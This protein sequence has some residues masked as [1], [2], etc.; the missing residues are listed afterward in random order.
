MLQKPHISNQYTMPLHSPR[1]HGLYTS[2]TSARCWHSR[3]A[4]FYP[5]SQKPH[6]CHLATMLP[7]LHRTHGPYTCVTSHLYRHSRPAPSDQE[8]QKKRSDFHLATTPM[9]IP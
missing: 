2:V 9:H 1:T 6:D 3:P 7:H 5:V 8:S 4:P